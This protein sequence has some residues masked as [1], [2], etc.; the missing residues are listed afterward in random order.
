MDNVPSQRMHLGRNRHFALVLARLCLLAFSRNS[1]KVVVN[2]HNNEIWLPDAVNAIRNLTALF[3]L[4]M[5][6]TA[7]QPPNYE[8]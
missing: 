8:C 6:Q 5:R 7:I 1:P 4:P 3:P 2:L